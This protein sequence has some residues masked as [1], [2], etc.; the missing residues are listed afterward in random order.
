MLFTYENETY[1]Y[2]GNGYYRQE[3]QTDFAVGISAGVK[4]TTKSGFTAVA[5]GGISLGYRF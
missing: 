4:F 2:N 1:D 3:D 5:R